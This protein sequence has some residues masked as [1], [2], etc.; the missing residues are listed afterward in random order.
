M[1]S[2]NRSDARDNHIADYYKTPVPAIM[3]FLMEYFNDCPSDWSNCHI[4]DPCAGGVR[5]KEFMSYPTA[6]DNYNFP[7]QISTIDVREDSPAETICDYLRHKPTYKPDIII[8][9]PPFSLAIEIIKKA[10]T[11]VKEG[12]LVIMLLRL[13]FFGSQSRYKFWQENMPERCYV[14][15]QRMKFTD[16]GTDSIEYMHCVWRKGFNPKETKLRII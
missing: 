1:S 12:G 2:T 7:K 6:L 15:S 3:D 10:L 8:T 11:E 5:G 9:N 16:K 14:H 13:N 4:L